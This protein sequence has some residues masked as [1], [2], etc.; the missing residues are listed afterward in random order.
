ME[1]QSIVP[2]EPLHDKK[3]QNEKPQI[4][5]NGKSIDNRSR[6]SNSRTKARVENA[7]AYLFQKNGADSN[8]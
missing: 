2:P 8:S 4:A 6:N 3:Y 7:Q 1:C 5:G